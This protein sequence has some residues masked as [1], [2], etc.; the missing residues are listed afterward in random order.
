MET[1]A[2]VLI[3]EDELENASQLKGILES[4]EFEIVGIA[5]TC[6]EAY[7]LF[8]NYLPDLLVCRIYLSNGEVAI[9]FVE[10]AR[11][12]KKA[13]IIY[14]SSHDDEE[15]LNKAMDSSPE[16]YI[17]LPYTAM[18]LLVA[19]KCA[20]HKNKVLSACNIHP[21]PTSRELEI[22]QHLVKGES[23]RKI[24]DTLC[25]SYETV[26][27]HRKNIYKKFGVSSGYET[28]ALAFQNQWVL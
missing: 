27:T 24:A 9:N 13:P 1:Y 17:T 4:S 6:K 2:K 8:I 19:A 10:E 14:V 26:K 21:E 3:L 7:N 12:I 18:Q 11:E 25:I 22:I 15:T 16:S 23:S 20:L 5:N 28:V